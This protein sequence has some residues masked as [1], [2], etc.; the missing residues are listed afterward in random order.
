MN[1]DFAKLIK[2]VSSV[3]LGKGLFGKTSTVLII[4]IVTIGFIAWVSGNTWV[5]LA[6]IVMI[7]LIVPYILI[8]LIK[9]AEKTP[10]TVILE[11]AEFILHQQIEYASKG[12]P[13]LPIS[14]GQ[15]IVGK[16]YIVSADDQQ[17]LDNPDLPATETPN[18]NQGEKEDQNGNG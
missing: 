9:L 16:P 13:T 4:L 14:H 8:K 5:C 11:G 18:T 6:A 15:F 1:V 2:N 17:L 7:C 3:K 12:M 10:Q